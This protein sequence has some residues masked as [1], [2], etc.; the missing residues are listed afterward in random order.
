MERG[1]SKRAKF[2]FFKKFQLYINYKTYS[3][4]NDIYD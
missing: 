2:L 1:E 4:A 3:K